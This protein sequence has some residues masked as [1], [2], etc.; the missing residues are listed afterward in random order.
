MIGKI[1]KNPY[2]CLTRIFFL[3]VYGVLGSV[4]LLFDPLP[5]ACKLGASC[6][7]RGVRWALLAFFSL[8]F[9]KAD[10]LNGLYILVLAVFIL[11]LADGVLNF[12]T[13][14]KYFFI[15][16]GKRNE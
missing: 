9:K 3:A 6:P 15:R 4:M 10:S 13:T 1:W 14:Y 12:K 16:K 5:S 2:F 8:D 7:F 11:M